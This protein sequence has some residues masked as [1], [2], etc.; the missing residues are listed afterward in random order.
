MDLTGLLSD[1]LA[2]A[3]RIDL[4]RKGLASDGEEHDGR[5]NYEDGLST[6][7][8]SFQEAQV[9]ADPKILILAE[10][11][12][13]EQELQF[14]DEADTITSSSLTQAIRSFDDA[15]LALE[16][17]EEPGYK[18]A[19]KTYP[20]KREY[21]IKGFPKD[22]FHCACMAHYTRISNVLR[23]PGINMKEKAVLQQRMSNLGSAR[24]SYIEK[25]KKALAL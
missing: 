14:C 9:T 16:A 10:Y 4:G 13:L 11:T 7:L 18:T 1:V 8:G 5:L 23:S 24:E 6:A 2:G 19:E 25:Q 21:R 15:L 17:V 3:A 20:H 12:F 22:A